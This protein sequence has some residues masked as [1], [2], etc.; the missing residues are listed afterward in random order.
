MTE[1]GQLADE[2]IGQFLDTHLTHAAHYLNDPW[3]SR[4][5]KLLR[6]FCATTA[7]QLTDAGITEGV[8]RTVLTGAI[9]HMMTGHDQPPRAEQLAQAVQPVSP[10]HPNAQGLALNRQEKT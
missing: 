8:I 5:T 6:H 4:D 3:F 7:D 10:V 1:S 2:L 9:N